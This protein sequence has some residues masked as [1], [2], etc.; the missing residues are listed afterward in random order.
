MA[1]LI[2]QAA[3]MSLR[4]GCRRLASMWYVFAANR[5]E[6]CGLVSYSSHVITLLV[7]ELS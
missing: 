3:L 7:N 1:I 2:C 4:K 5:L 6:K